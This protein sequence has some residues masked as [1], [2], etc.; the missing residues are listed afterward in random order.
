[1][2]VSYNRWLSLSHIIVR[3]REF[4]SK[5]SSFSINTASS[6]NENEKQESEVREEICGAERLGMSQN[7]KKNTFCYFDKDFYSEYI[8]ILRFSLIKILPDN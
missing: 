2:E 3:M 8:K 5:S 7:R 4:Q 1:M 6:S